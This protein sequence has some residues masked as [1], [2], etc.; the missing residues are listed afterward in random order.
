MQTYRTN[1]P[2]R[3]VPPRPALL[4]SEG[5]LRRTRAASSR[6]ERLERL[7]RASGLAASRIGRLLAND[8]ALLSDLRAGREPRARTL[9][10]I[11]AWIATRE[12]THA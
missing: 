6:L 1:P 2:S 9:A 12:A 4:P 8:P 10:R 11:D 7:I 5:Y 3:S